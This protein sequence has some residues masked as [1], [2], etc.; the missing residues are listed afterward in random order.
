ML[1]ILIRVEKGYIDAHNAMQHRLSARGP[2]LMSGGFDGYG[3][4]V[5][6]LQRG[7]HDGI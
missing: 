5:G 3:A 1:G 6:R 4:C 2:V 7:Q